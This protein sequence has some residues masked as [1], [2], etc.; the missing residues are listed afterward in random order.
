MIFLF[1]VDLLF[2]EQYLDLK[3]KKQENSAYQNYSEM[4]ADIYSIVAL[5]CIDTSLNTLETLDALIK[6]IY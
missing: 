4:Y 1:L 5:L 6:R 2:F 3:S